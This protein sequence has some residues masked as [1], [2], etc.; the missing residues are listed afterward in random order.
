MT[1]EMGPQTGEGGGR[2]H[3]LDWLRVIAFGL[4]IFYHIGMFY[5]TW[6][7][8]VKSV[9]ASPAPEWAMLLLNPWRLALLFFISGVAFRFISDKTPAPALAGSRLYRLGLPIVF[10]MIVVVTPQA[11]FEARQAGVID[12]GYV[13][14]W[15]RYLAGDPTLPMSTPTWNHLWYVVYLLTYSLIIVAVLPVLRPLTASRGE[16]FINLVA[17]GPWRVLT[18][19]VLPFLVYRFALDVRFET[20][21]DLFNDW[22]NHAHRF[23]MFLIGYGIAKND[24]F[25]RSIDR[26]LPFAAGLCVTLGLGLSLVWAQWDAFVEAAPVWLVNIARALRIWYAWLFIATLLG[27]AQRFLNRPSPALRY[28]NGAIF[29]YYI[30]HQTIIIAAGYALTQLQLGAW[31]EFALLVAITA[32]GCAVLYELVVRRAPVLRPL[33]GAKAAKR[34]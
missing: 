6:G 33:L 3:D 28:L 18:L 23:T 26:A 22:A 13:A 25:W 31:T 10:G 11:Y 27:L 19:I 14:F 15:G 7:W 16:R 2:R 21:H 29:S 9:Y 5:V 1:F 30:L 32:F 24:R 12:E 34:T 17:G 8:H 20:T 4:L